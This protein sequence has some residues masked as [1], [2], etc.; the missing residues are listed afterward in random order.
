M[1][2]LSPEIERE[3]AA[4]REFDNTY[5]VAFANMSDGNLAA[6]ARFWMQHCEAPKRARPGEPVYDSTFWYIIL[7]ELLKRL[8]K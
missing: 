2:K 8:E 1:F 3:L 4:S 5:K 7:P 6:S